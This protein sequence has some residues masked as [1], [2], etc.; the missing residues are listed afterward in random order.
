MPELP[1]VETTAQGIKKYLIGET[2]TDVWTDLAVKNQRAPH[3][4]LF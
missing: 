4:I 3:Y 1:E 2:I